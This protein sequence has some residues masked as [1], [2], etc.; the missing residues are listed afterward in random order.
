MTYKFHNKGESVKYKGNEPG[1]TNDKIHELIHGLEEE[2]KKNS[3][4]EKSPFHG[5]LLFVSYTEERLENLK[6]FLV[7]RSKEQTHHHK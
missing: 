5:K 2:N 6:V 3:Q 7:T 1:R 4:H